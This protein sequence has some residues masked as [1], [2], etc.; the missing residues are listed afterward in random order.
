MSSR[1]LFIQYKLYFR[2]FVFSSPLFMQL[3][4]YYTT[5]KVQ[6]AASMLQIK[7]SF[8]QLALM[9]H[10]DK[11]PGNAVAGATFREIQEAYETLSDPERREEY[12]YKRWYNRSIQETFVN[13]VLSPS[14]I[15]YECIRLNNY[16]NTVN[17]LRVDFDGL[18]YHIR[19]LLSDKNIGI[20]Q[21]FNDEVINARI[22]EKILLPASVLPYQYVEPVTG[23]LF[24]VAGGNQVL[25]A[26]IQAF[27][28]QQ[29]QKNIWYRYKAA[30]VVML[31]LLICWIIYLVSK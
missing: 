18:S 15:L 7:K 3:K 16:M 13:E 14:A 23:L 17:A 6:P 24:R 11:N 20:L 12:N 21:Q 19:Q 4:D 9:Y 31:T 25:I 1:C 26:Q 5:L 2:V 22:V 27:A 10:P 29:K 30:F 8:R 28:R